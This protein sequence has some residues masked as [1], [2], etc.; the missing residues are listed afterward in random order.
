MRACWT[1][2]ALIVKHVVAHFHVKWVISWQTHQEQN[3]YINDPGLA[4]TNDSAYRLYFYVLGKK[5]QNRA[6][7]LSSHEQVESDSLQSY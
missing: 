4:N 6:V 2:P 7:H 3:Y 5:Q 1:S